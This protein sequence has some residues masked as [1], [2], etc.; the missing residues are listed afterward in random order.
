MTTLCP[1]KEAIQPVHF[2]RERARQELSQL[3]NEDSK[4]LCASLR[5]ESLQPASTPRCWQEA[6]PRD[7]SSLQ[8]EAGPLHDLRHLKEG[9]DGFGALP[10]TEELL[11][12]GEELWYELSSISTQIPKVFP[13]ADNFLLFWWNDTSKDKEIKISVYEEDGDLWWDLVL[14]SGNEQIYGSRPFDVDLM[15]SMIGHYN[16][17]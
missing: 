14:R 16:L 7:L 5:I 2:Y 9:W 11:D 10:L 6:L 13:G 3:R 12:R 15:T 17:L 4:N 1:T 8:Y